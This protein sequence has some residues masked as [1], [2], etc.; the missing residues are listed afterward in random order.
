MKKFFDKENIIFNLMTLAVILYTAVYLVRI[1]LA[2][3]QTGMYPNE[4]REAANI[5]MTQSIL[6]GVNPYSLSTLNAA[7]PSVCYLYG[8]LM[9]LI[10]VPFA[11][12]LPNVSL[13]TIHYDIS[14]ASI[15]ISAVL[16]G[17]MVKEHSR[18]MFA[19]ACAFLLTI[20]CHWRYGYV[21]GAPDSLGLCVMIA[22]LFVLSRGVDSEETDE[23]SLIYRF[24]PEI[25]ALLTVATLF[26]KQYFLM[27][28]ATGAVYLFYIN[29]K[30][31]LRYAASGIVIS[32]VLFSAI[33]VTCPLYWTYAIYFLKGPGAGAAMGKTG[34]SYNNMQISYLGGMLLMLFIAALAALIFMIKGWI[35]KKLVNNQKFIMLFWIHSVIA[36]AVLRYIGNNDGAFLSYY[37]Q[38]F[39][40][41]LIVISVCA[42]DSLEIPFGSARVRMILTTLACLIFIGYTIYKVEPRLIINRLS[43]EEMGQ[44]EQAYELADKYVG[45][46][47]ETHFTED[48]SAAGLREDIYY[49]PP[50]NYHGYSNGEYV[51]NDGQPFVFS[52][53][54]AKRHAESPLMQKL[55]PHAGEVIAQHLEF[56]EQLRQKVLRGDYELVMNLPE[57]DVVFTDED[58]SVNYKKEGTYSLRTGNWAWDIDF[59]VKK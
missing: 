16:V 20:F 15:I 44:W 28:A 13:W 5:A 18:R 6:S 25:A 1:F 22:V 49:F 59:W 17:I 38:L 57:T 47:D 8:P 33:T 55:F 34:I 50:L 39:T 56:R 53:K 26:T 9:S 27:V 36:V 45:T 10:A 24:K 21:Y 7:V 12:L 46:A 19:P 2:A 40:P 32:A 43:A 48:V 11:W 51:Y 42:L 4:Y 30:L 54:F 37:L 41:A 3:G 31:F 52:E 14:I 29:R 58:L 35:T 23:K